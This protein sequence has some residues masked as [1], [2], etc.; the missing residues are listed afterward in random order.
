MTWEVA[1]DGTRHVVPSRVRLLEDGAFGFQAEQRD[2]SRPLVVDPVLVWG[3]YFGGSG[4]QTITAL[5]CDASGAVYFGGSALD[6]VPVTPGAYQTTPSHAYV[7]KINPSLSGAAQLVWC[8]Y[9]GL[10]ETDVHAI[11]LGPTGEVVVAG[12]GAM[13]VTAGA[14]S[15]VGNIGISVLSD[16]GSSLLYGT[17]VP[18]SGGGYDLRGTLI[19]EPDGRIVIGVNSTDSTW[20]TTP[21][22][23][24]SSGYTG[25]SDLWFARIDR[26]LNGSAQLVWATYFGAP[27][28]DEV[29]GWI[30]ATPGQPGIITFAGAGARTATPRTHSSSPS[31]SANMVGRLDP[32]QVGAA[33]LVFNHVFYNDGWGYGAGPR[34]PAMTI[35]PNGDIVMMGIRDNVVGFN[36]LYRFSPDG[37]TVLQEWPVVVSNFPNIDAKSIMVSLGG[38]VTIFGTVSG[39][40]IPVTP[41]ALQTW[42]GGSNDGYLCQVNPATQQILYGTYLGTAAT[43]FAYRSCAHLSGNL[44]T[45]ALLSNGDALPL[46]NPLMGYQGGSDGYL[47]RLELPAGG[48]SGSGIGPRDVELL[49]LDGDGD[50]DVT[51]ANE[52]SD[53]VSLRTNNGQGVLGAEA[54][55]SLTA[56]DHGPVALA[57][58]DLDNDGQRDDLA[59]V[60]EI[61]STFVLL[62]NPSS[63]SPGRNSLASGGLRPASVASADVD[64][65]PIDDL[66]VGCQG[67]PFAGGAGLFLARNGGAAVSMAIPVPHPTQVVKVA[68]ADLDGDGDMDLAAVARG[69]SDEV[70]LYAGD[71]AGAFT[72]A[73]ALSLPTTGLA[74]GLCC[75]DFDG[76]GTNDIAVVLPQLFPPSQ[77]LRVY[78]RTSTGALAPGLFTAGS[79]IATTG[80]FAIDLACGDLADGSISGFSTW[81]DLAQANAGSGTVTVRHQYTG[82]GFATSTSPSAG[83]TP[84]A[85]AIG[86]LNGDACAD[87]VVANQGSDDVTVVLTTPPALA[88]SY[89]TGCGGPT[90]SAVGLPTSGNPAFGVR[91]SNAQAV[92]PLLLLFS[93]GVAD[94]P[95]PPSPCRVLLANPILQLLAFT[96]ASGQS[97][98]LFAIPNT[99]S[100]LAAD[101]YFQGAVFHVP[102]G[103]FADTLDISNALRLQIGQ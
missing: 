19:V 103:A 5:T 23:F 14:Y 97:T 77:S 64:T 76:G 22:A 31:A 95:L 87:L 46:Q 68:I 29:L 32:S 41:D 84:V 39:S 92:A 88:Q 62:T 27:A 30:A 43:E 70:L 40:G 33:Q 49:D 99:S 63:A 71:G 4:S 61:S 6:P 37:A 25:G 44:L 86:D 17:R 57:R 54:T 56:A 47:A 74:N 75:R 7:A 94:V 96:N 34:S 12:I 101:V 55:V 45:V 58:C 35:A 51:T 21:G 66:V 20:P 1:A 93:S 11:A 3:S 42:H 28:A 8:T 65:D 59:I 67:D 38:E 18:G 9:L 79:D 83:T 15:T 85:V 72:F 24:Q 73:G 10:V 78:R 50:L 89:G 53:N 91:V 80:T 52:T 102:G 16:D 26:T 36:V 81:T 48:G 100:L 60:C 13:P 69:S 98:T 90:I 2:R 82:G